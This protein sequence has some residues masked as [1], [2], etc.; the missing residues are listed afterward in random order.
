MSAQHVL[1]G[2]DPGVAN[3]AFAVVVVAADGHARLG[4]FV[5]VN[6]GSS[7][8]E[9]EVISRRTAQEMASAV[10]RFGPAMVAVED[11]TC[12]IKKRPKLYAVSAAAAA[13]AEALGVPTRWYHPADV[14]R[15]RGIP[16]L[17][18]HQKNKKAALE[19]LAALG[20]PLESD[21]VAD[22][23][24]LALCAADELLSKEPPAGYTFSE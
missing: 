18:N 12:M 5:E 20:L 24:L 23:V 9:V 8:T 2:V 14:K 22:A 11:M 10:R 13:A 17:R 19:Y 7:E 6:M 15:I 21:H 4:A 16:F 1:L 3:L